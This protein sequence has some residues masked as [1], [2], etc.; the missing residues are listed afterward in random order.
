MVE[1][2]R[3]PTHIGW[4]RPAEPFTLDNL[5]G[6]LERVETEYRKQLNASA[7]K[8]RGDKR[9]A[10]KVHGGATLVY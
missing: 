2:E 7:P 10:R 3:L 1:N 8:R 5:L 6:N 9:V 4:K